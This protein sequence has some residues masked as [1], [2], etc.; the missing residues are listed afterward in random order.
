MLKKL[1][2]RIKAYFAARELNSQIAKEELSVYRTHVPEIQRESHETYKIG[3]FTATV[4]G[5][6]AELDL[7]MLVNRVEKGRKQAQKE[8]EILDLAF[9]NLVKVDNE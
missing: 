2:N 9:S 1:L 8:E 5:S 3:D 4:V 6:K 7:R